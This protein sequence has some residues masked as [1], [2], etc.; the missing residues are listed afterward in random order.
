MARDGPRRGLSVSEVAPN[1]PVLVG[2]GVVTQREE[3]AS[4]AAEPLDLMLQAVRTAALDA[5][6]SRHGDLVRAVQWIGVPQGRWRYRD[7]ARAIAHAVGATAAHSVLASVGVLQQSLLGEACRAIASGERDAAVV[8]GGDAGYRI[9]RAKLAG[10]RAAERQQ[11][12]VPDEHLVPAEELR[13]P[14]ELRAGAKMPVGLYAIIESAHRAAH[15][16][17]VDA[18]RD[19]MARTYARFSAIAQDNPHAWNRERLE[20]AQIRDASQRN[21]MQAFPY[22]RRHCSTWNVDQAGALIFCSAGRAE[23]L[24]IAPRRWVFPLAS[25]ESNHMTHVAARVAL[26]AC[27]GAGIAGRAVLDATGLGIADVDLLDL[28]SCFPVAVATYA[29]ALGIPDDRDL[30]VTGSM[31]FAGGPYNNYVLQATCRIAELL[32]AGAGRH[33]LVSSVS[34]ILTKQAFGLWSR[35]AG[36]AEYVQRDVSAEVAR[37]TATLPIVDAE[38][39]AGRIAGYTVLHERDGPPVGVAVIDVPGGRAVARTTS[40]GDVARMQSEEL[41]GADVRLAAGHTFILAA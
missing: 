10:E 41:C 15:G 28:Y 2:V 23:S 38:S 8:T 6:P 27:P 18:H 20:A 12:T 35:A 22:T 24:G 14:A 31:A 3:D 4:R 7:P 1:T 16:W 26:G 5:T 36:P 25:A 9:L 33:G 11:D 32:R 37:A 30:T 34:G 13:H 19:R 21:P 40:G 29:E 39:G 17:S